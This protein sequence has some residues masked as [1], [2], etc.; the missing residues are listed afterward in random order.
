MIVDT[1]V[2]VSEI[3]NS[4]ASAAE[5]QAIATSEIANNVEQASSGTQIITV[6]IANLRTASGEAGGAA[7]D[8]SSTTGNLSDRATEL[9]KQVETSLTQAKD[10]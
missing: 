2:K 7:K 8:V 9:R 4:I 1:I 6:S 5:E 3:A 10:A